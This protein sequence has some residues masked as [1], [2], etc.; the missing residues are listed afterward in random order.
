[1]YNFLS[2]NGQLIAF[3][4]GLLLV[5]IFV[6]SAITGMNS[7]ADTP[8]REMLYESKIFDIGLIAAR[9]LAIAALILMII[10]IIRSVIMNPKGSLPLIIA[11][12]AIAIIFFIFRGMDS[13]EITKSMYKYGVS[14]GE[15]GIVSGGI[16]VATLMFFGAWIVLILSEIRGMFR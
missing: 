11:A 4:L 7:Y 6:I 5:V 14:A 8:T 2:K 13:G 3:L 16:W 12:V 10:F 15:G 1:M 9:F